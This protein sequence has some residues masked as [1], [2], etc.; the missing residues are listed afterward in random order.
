MM[1]LP[2][3]MLPVKTPPAPVQLTICVSIVTD[4]L[5]L[6]TRVTETGELAAAS[7]TV[8]LTVWLQVY[9]PLSSETC[10]TDVLAT[11]PTT[12]KE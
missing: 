10:V 12:A 4:P 3:W 8:T 11:S 7:L 6:L 2:V 1:P 5:S 9:L